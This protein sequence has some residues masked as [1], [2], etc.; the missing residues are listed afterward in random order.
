MKAIG[1]A[2][3][4][5]WKTFLRTEENSFNKLHDIIMNVMPDGFEAAIS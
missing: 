4:E 2:V 5:I 1:N 3:E